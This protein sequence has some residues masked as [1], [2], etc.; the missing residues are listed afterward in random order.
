MTLTR[1]DAVSAP[2]SRRINISTSPPSPLQGTPALAKTTFHTQVLRVEPEHSHVYPASPSASPSPDINARLSPHLGPL[3]H[4]THPRAPT[5][6][7]VQD[8]GFDKEARRYAV[9]AIGNLALTVDFHGELVT[10]PCVE[11][12]KGCMSSSDPETVFNAA[13]AMNKI[14]INEALL[15]SLGDL[16]VVP[17]L[18]GAMSNGDIDTVAQTVG[19][20]RHLAMCPENRLLMLDAG[21][22]HPPPATPLGLSLTVSVHSC[23]T[24]VRLTLSCLDAARGPLFQSPQPPF[25]RHRRRV[26]GAARDGDGQRRPGDAA[27]V[28]CVA[29][30]PHPHR[31]PAHARGCQRAPAGL[32]ALFSS[33]F[34]CNPSYNALCNGPR[35]SRL[36]GA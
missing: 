8:H 23:W 15:K 10:I 4:L 2:P 17:V 12:V 30:V 11:A 14:T 20:L 24:Q 16:G 21:N 22:P 5:P 1:L 28:R 29:I 34:I 25:F 33:L 18:V 35:R 26:A 9:L 3:P 7:A 31:R 32:P 27:G 36:G 6:A 19:A 13:F